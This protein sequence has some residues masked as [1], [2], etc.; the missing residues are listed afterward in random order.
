MMQEAL[1]ATARDEDPPHRAHPIPGSPFFFLKLKTN[2]LRQ[3]RRQGSAVTGWRAECALAS[4]ARI[5]SD[6]SSGLLSCSVNA[7]VC[8]VLKQRHVHI[9]LGGRASF[10]GGARDWGMPALEVLD[11]H[12][13]GILEETLIRT[14]DSG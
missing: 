9:G 2:S 14:G 7:R 12:V 1:G 4:R 8:E 5:W 6:S 11:F 10:S 13:V 3:L